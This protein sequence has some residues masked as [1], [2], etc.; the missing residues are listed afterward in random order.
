MSEGKFLS[1]AL[2]LLSLLLLSLGPVPTHGAGLA[3]AGGARSPA[4]AGLAQPSDGYSLAW[5]TVDGGGHT[6]SSGG[7]YALGG[8]V[9]QPDAGDVAGGSYTLG[10]GFWEGWAKVLYRIYLPLVLRS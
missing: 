4:E 5:Y 6:W 7:T 3:A 8:T 2:V 10:A 9:G 1:M